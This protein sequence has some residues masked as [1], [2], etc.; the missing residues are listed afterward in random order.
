MLLYESSE[1]EGTLEIITRA[2]LDDE[3]EGDR[4]TLYQY[5][6]RGDKIISSSEVSLYPEQSTKIVNMFLNISAKKLLDNY[7]IE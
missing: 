2:Y 5:L 7:K 4:L 6:F 3:G 1:K